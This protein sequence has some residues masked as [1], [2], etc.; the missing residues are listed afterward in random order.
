MYIQATSWKLEEAIQLFYIGND[1]GAA[2]ASSPVLPVENDGL[3]PGSE[4]HVEPGNVK[5]D[6]GSEV[7]APLPVKRDVLYDGPP[8]YRSSR[9]G[10]SPNEARTVVPFRNF[11]EELKH[12]GV[13]EEDKGATSSKA[14][15][16][17]DRNL[18]TMYRPPFALMYP[19]PFEKAKEAAKKPNDRLL[20]NIANLPGEFSSTTKMYDLTK[21]FVKYK[22]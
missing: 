9:M 2:V 7:R 19:G 17:R 3:L 12:P 21:C 14:D 11:N 10:Y 20:V 8:R 5:Q 4:N 13:W 1:G 15:T 6:D 16:S 18:A 22:H